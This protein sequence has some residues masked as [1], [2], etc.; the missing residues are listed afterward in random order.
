MALRAS[1]ACDAGDEEEAAAAAVGEDERAAATAVYVSESPLDAP[2]AGGGAGGA[3]P[4]H[5]ASGTGDDQPA[6]P[7]V[8]CVTYVRWPVASCPEPERAGAGA[9]AAGGPAARRES[10]LDRTSPVEPSGGD[11]TWALGMAC[12]TRPAAR[13]T[14]A[15][16]R[17][18]ASQQF[19]VRGEEVVSVS[20]LQ[21]TASDLVPTALPPLETPPDAHDAP[22]TPCSPCGRASALNGFGDGVEGGPWPSGRDGYV[23]PGQSWQVRRAGG[24]GGVAHSRD[25][26]RT[27]GPVPE[28]LGGAREAGSPVPEADQVRRGVGMDAGLPYAP[29]ALVAVC[30]VRCAGTH[31]PVHA[32]TPTR[33]SSSEGSPPQP[34]ARPAPEASAPPPPT[35]PPAPPARGAPGRAR[36]ATVAAGPVSAPPADPPARMRARSTCAGPFFHAPLV[37][38][39]TR[40]A[41]LSPA[42]ELR[43]RL[44][45]GQVSKMSTLQWGLTSDFEGLE[46][47]RRCRL[48]RERKES[49][50]AGPRTS[51]DA[52]ARPRTGH[53][54][55]ARAAGR[56]VASPRL[57][58]SPRSSPGKGW[59]HVNGFGGN[60]V[61]SEG[62]GETTKAATAGLVALLR[63]LRAAVLA[64]LGAG[65]AACWPAPFDLGPHSGVL[66]VGSGFGKVTLHVAEAALPRQSVGV[67][68]VASRFDAAQRALEALL[69]PGTA[70]DDPLRSAEFVYGDA[71][72]LPDLGCFT[73][74]YLFD[75][76]FSP[77][78]LCALGLALD[79]CAFFVLVSYRNPKEW[80][81]FGLTKVQPVARMRMRTTGKEGCMAYVYINMDHAPP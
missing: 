69:P 36:S 14:D 25:G 20:P 56:G 3:R 5:S 68:C 7:R 65:P 47:K 18:A 37:E 29:P 55:R 60:T 75:R 80:W 39:T 78:T 9:N 23:C 76:V 50:G 51:R 64:H 45:Y 19:T 72:R 34:N 1:S 6:P 59:K 16:P 73:H 48:A 57:E 77:V 43:L 10:G 79:R 12:E 35:H 46:E 31:G 66:D 62:Y 26:G 17:L 8:C 44:A 27:L 11:G 52:R 32:A 13:I 28:A 30:V 63:H 38:V 71:T 15:V 61:G 49:D 67:E 2:R 21:G 70:A 53:E 33:V 81:S 4:L 41:A 74:I 42:Q 22:A 54:A 40:A 58:P 24:G